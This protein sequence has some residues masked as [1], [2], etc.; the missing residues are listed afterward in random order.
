[1][2]CLENRRLD[3]RII[4]S[5]QMLLVK[6]Q[7]RSIYMIIISYANLIVYRRYNRKM[8]HVY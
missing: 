1:M 6:M 4:W 8:R 5:T 3:V 7:L 2:L